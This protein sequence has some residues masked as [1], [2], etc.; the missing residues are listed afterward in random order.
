V[1]ETENLA[2]TDKGELA[3]KKPSVAGLR[4]AMEEKDVDTKALEIDLQR[5]LGL[6]VDIRHI[7]GKGGEVRI[8]Y[9]QLEQLDE[10]CRL[11]TRPRIVAPAPGPAGED[12]G[13]DVVY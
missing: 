3:A 8:R 9:A 6:D 13:D 4:A 1:R 10:I 12:I 2:K 7:N 5:A 11:L